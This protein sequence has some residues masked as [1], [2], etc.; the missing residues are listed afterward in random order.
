MEE[1]QTGVGIG[2]GEMIGGNN[3]SSVII[4][5]TFPFIKFPCLFIHISIGEKGRHGNTVIGSKD[6][7]FFIFPYK[8]KIS[9][10]IFPPVHLQTEFI[11]LL[12]A[13]S[14]IHITIMISGKIEEGL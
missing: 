12:P 1:M 11:R 3:D 13:F 5:F 14:V 9:Q 7:E 2:K 6:P 8:G 10:S 4:F